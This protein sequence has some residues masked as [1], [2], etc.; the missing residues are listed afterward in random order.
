MVNKMF[1]LI[2][3]NRV[4]WETEH[5]DITAAFLSIKTVATASGRN[6]TYVSARSRELSHSDVAW[7][8]LQCFYQEPLGG[9]MSSG[10]FVYSF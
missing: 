10:S 9:D 4:Q 6:M 2:R 3:K 5:R 8:A 7:A 1:D